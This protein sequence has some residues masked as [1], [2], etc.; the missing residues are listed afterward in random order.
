MLDEEPSLFIE[1]A[2]CYCTKCYNIINNTGRPLGNY[3]HLSVI[4]KGETSQ[5]EVCYKKTS[6]LNRI[7]LE[8]WFVLSTLG[9]D[10][11]TVYLLC[12]LTA[13]KYLVA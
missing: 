7:D 1:A 5:Q 4:G 8:G 9:S 2:P 3:A 11:F 13:K 6:P 12:A 10:V